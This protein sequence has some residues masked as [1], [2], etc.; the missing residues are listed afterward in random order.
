MA[1]AALNAMMLPKQREFGFLVMIE[2]DFFPLALDMT[3]F[4][5]GAKAALVF[6]VLPMA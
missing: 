5:L 1:T 2:Q 3:A 4:A 6:V